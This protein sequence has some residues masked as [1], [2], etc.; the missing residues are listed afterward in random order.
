MRPVASLCFDEKCTPLATRDGT[1]PKIPD[2]C[3]A[4]FTHRRKHEFPA[5]LGWHLPEAIF[6]LPEICKP[7]WPD[8]S[9]TN[10]YLQADENTF[11]SNA[12]YHMHIRNVATTMNKKSH[13]HQTRTPT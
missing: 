1:L 13:E 2:D 3:K 10:T 9:M 8:F 4:T 7:S 11:G 6:Y 12:S 5:R